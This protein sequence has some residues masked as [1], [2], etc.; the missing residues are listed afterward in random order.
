M[1]IQQLDILLR[2]LI[3]H[4][5]ADFVFQTNKMVKAK[6]RGLKSNYFYAHIALVGALTYLLMADWANW[7]VPTLIMV[8]HG[9]IDW[10]KISLKN[11]NAWIFI[12]DQLLHI[13][14]IIIIWVLISNNSFE[15]LFNNWLGYGLNESTLILAL[16][17]LIV[18]MPIGILIGYLTKSW[19]EELDDNEKNSL[20]NAGKWIGAIERILILTFILSN[21]WEPI[22][23]LLAAKSIFRFG[24][25]RKG[26]QR[27]RTEYILIGTLI[28]FTSAIILGILVHFIINK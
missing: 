11:D 10:F 21:H 5:L 9:A 14:S 24:D 6:K 18:S 4:L 3:A 23:F 26:K 7:W 2:I 28:S 20:K 15:Q 27:K 19:Q 12:A 17:Y 22:G 8:L 25:L 1:E 13:I 16:A